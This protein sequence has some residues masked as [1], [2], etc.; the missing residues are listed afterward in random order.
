MTLE[1]GLDYGLDYHLRELILPPS[2]PAIAGNISARGMIQAG[3]IPPP[4]MFTIAGDVGAL[5]TVLSAMVGPGMVV[6]IGF[7]S[8]ND[9]GQNGTT[10]GGTAT[11]TVVTT[12]A[13]LES[14][15]AGSTPKVVHVSGTLAGSGG[16]QIGSNTTILG[17]GPTAFIDGYALAMTQNVQNIIIRNVK[18]N[19]PGGDMITAQASLPFLTHH[20]WIDHCTFI[21]PGGDGSIDLTQGTTYWTISWCHFMQCNKTLLSGRHDG[22]PWEAQGTGRGTE[23]HNWFEGCFQRQPKRQ[24]FGWTHSLNNFYDIDSGNFSQA[25]DCEDVAEAYIEGNYFKDA[26]GNGP[27]TADGSTR[28]KDAGDNILDNSNAIDELDPDN[29]FVPSTIYSYTVDTPSTIN[30]IVPAGAGVGNI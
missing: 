17:L 4:S 30:T 23:H 27:N 5:A 3:L 13:E 22:P 25:I 15:V 10:G 18:C 20:I 29:C 12:R 9:L 11:P 2:L 6:P 1:Y 26:L 7:A 8:I 16:V 19:N 21:G 28:C 24:E 14:E